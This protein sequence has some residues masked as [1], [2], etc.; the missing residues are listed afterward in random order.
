MNNM[1]RRKHRKV[2][3]I[4]LD[5]G[6]DTAR[7]P[8]T[9]LVVACGQPEHEAVRSVIGEWLVPLL[10]KEFLAEQHVIYGPVS[11]LEQEPTFK[12]VGEERGEQTRTPRQ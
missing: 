12:P 1:N 9:V 8:E 11:R 7:H 3:A 10:V 2:S 5:K 6:A 4:D